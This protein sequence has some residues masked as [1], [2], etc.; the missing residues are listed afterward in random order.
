MQ[1][2]L[3]RFTSARPR[4]VVSQA[5]GLE[6]LAE[7]HAEAEATAKHLD[8]DERKAVHERM[9]KI[10]ARCACAPDKIGWRGH[11][12]GELETFDFAN[13]SLYPLRRDPRG[14]GSQAR[15]EAFARIVD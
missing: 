14:A 11:S 6:W 1:P 2:L 9:R 5:R 3:C 15:T 13:H 4:H 10:I 12:L 7:A 8:D